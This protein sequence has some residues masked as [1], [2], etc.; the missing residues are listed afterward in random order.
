LPIYINEWMAGNT[1]TS[2]DAADG[3]FED[4]FELFNAGPAAWIFRGSLSPTPPRS[5]AMDH[6]DGT[7]IVPGGRLL[8]WADGEPEQNDRALI[9]TQNF[10]LNQSGEKIAL[11]T[12]LGALV[13]TVDFGSGTNDVSQ[14]AARWEWATICV[15]GNSHTAS[16]E[17]VW[18]Q[19]QHRAG[20]A[21][22]EQRVLWK[23]VS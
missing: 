10:R 21:A 1:L 9:C 6:P 19:C 14:A 3:D 17:R 8:V 12:P 15:Y 4:W 5:P 7:S 16:S 2:A 18:Q 13:D 20:S 22:I 11:F 23:M